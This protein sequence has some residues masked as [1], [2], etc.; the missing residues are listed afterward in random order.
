MPGISTEPPRANHQRY[1]GA[2]THYHRQARGAES[3]ARDE[4]VASEIL[5][6]LFTDVEIPG[7]REVRN[8]QH[9]RAPEHHH[10]NG[11]QMRNLDLVGAHVRTALHHRVGVG[12]GGRVIGDVQLLLHPRGC[13]TGGKRIA[14]RRKRIARRR[15][16]ARR[17]GGRERIRGVG[18]RRGR[19]RYF[20]A[21]RLCA[22]QNNRG[23]ADLDLIANVQ[24]ALV[25]PRAVHHRSRLVAEV[26]QRDVFRTGNLD[27]GVHPRGELVVHAQVALGIFAHLDDVLSH[28][29]AAGQL[30]ALVQRKR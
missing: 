30:I 10:F 22:L 27:Y 15:E 19:G 5:A 18:R 16:R 28:R 6:L 26:N 17:R 13:C 2:V 14:R 4:E 11:R 7:R 23:R 29:L 9:V 20:G 12:S 8:V 25:D 24:L 1:R 3:L 21:C